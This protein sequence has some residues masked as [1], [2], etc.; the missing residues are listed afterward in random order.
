MRQN[1]PATQ[2]IA[3]RR[4]EKVLSLRLAGL[5][6]AEIVE[7]LKSDPEVAPLPRGWDCRYAASDLRRLLD[8]EKRAAKEE[9]AAARELELR[10]L[11]S[12]YNRLSERFENGDMSVVEKML[13]V[14]ELRAKILGLFPTFSAELGPQGEAAMR[15]LVECART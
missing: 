13:R 2:L 10:R 9:V 4:R 6:Y 15:I 8:L 12:I 1:D 5:C 14:I 11:S 7:K 3:L